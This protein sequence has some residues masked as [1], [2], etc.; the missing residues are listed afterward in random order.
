VVCNSERGD[1]VRCRESRVPS[2][3]G[4][5]LKVEGCRVRTRRKSGTSRGKRR[6][7]VREGK[8][9]EEGRCFSGGILAWEMCMRLNFLGKLKK[10][11][12]LEEYSWKPL[13]GS[14][15]QMG[16]KNGQ[17]GKFKG[18]GKIKSEEDNSG[19]KLLDRGGMDL[20]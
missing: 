16:I 10:K 6:S 11:D 13:T 18:R 4:G 2:L 14:N 19:G 3:I 12:G 8:K 1:P 7:A 17:I 20:Y 5:L 15:R 9:D